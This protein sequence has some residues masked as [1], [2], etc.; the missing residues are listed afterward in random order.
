MDPVLRSLVED[1]LR[2]SDL[3]VGAAAQVREA[4]GAEQAAAG[5]RAQPVWLRSVTVE[6]FRGIGPPATLTLE[7]RPG[8]TVVTGRNGS[9]KSSFAEG[10]ELLLTGELKRWEKRPRAW[11][12]TW[13]CL[14]HTE[15]TRITAE[16]QLE[17][18]EDV[19]LHQTWPHGAG[20]G[21]ASGRAQAAQALAR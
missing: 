6:G 13:Q 8:L 7:P 20:Y 1:R 17:G 12:E 14:H 10:L 9:G 11:T 21:D 18:G 3:S 15:P 19:T 4:C 16:L 2:A 5:P